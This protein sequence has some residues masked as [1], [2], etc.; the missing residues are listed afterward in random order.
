M[1]LLTRIDLVAILVLG[2]VFASNEASAICLRSYVDGETAE[3]RLTSYRLPPTPSKKVG[4]RQR[5]ILTLPTPACLDSEAK[6]SLT[7]EIYSSE[8]A[9]RINFKRF[10]EKTVIVRGMPRGP[11]RSH[12]EA[13]ITMRVNDIRPR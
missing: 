3:G 4:E 5:Y 13:K 8:S 1:S 6:N 2:A 10:V 9:I 7:I 12:H 11:S